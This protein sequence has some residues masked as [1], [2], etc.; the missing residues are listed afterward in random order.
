MTRTVIRVLSN[1]VGQCFVSLEQT[2]VGQVDKRAACARAP[3]R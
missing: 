2:S 3:T 1:L